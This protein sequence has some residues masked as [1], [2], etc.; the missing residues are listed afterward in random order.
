MVT[1]KKR[2]Y[3]LDILKFICSILI[4]V[5]HFQGKTHFVW[6]LDIRSGRT[7]SSGQLVKLFFMI[8]GF[9]AANSFKS[10]EDKSYK[11]FL[12]H[13]AKRIMPMTTIATFVCL[14]TYFIY[15]IIY[16][17]Y[18]YGVQLGIW[19][20]INSFTMTYS[21]GALLFEESVVNN[22]LW[23]ICVLF[24]C[25]TFLYFEMW[26]KKQLNI[27]KFTVLFVSF[28]IF[29]G[30]KEYGIN[31][32]FLNITTADGYICFLLGIFINTFYSF[33]LSDENKFR[34]LTIASILIILGTFLLGLL[35]YDIFF[36]NPD[37]I[38]TFIIFPCVM[39][40]FLYMDK[41]LNNSVCSILGGISFNNYI[42]HKSFISILLCL[43]KLTPSLFSQGYT[44][45]HEILLVLIVVLFST[46]SYLY[47]E[48][49]LEKFVNGKLNY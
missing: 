41:Y 49:P 9:F 4:I 20:I 8:S 46:F 6:F 23:Y 37:Y 2:I 27:N 44:Y 13:K 29:L 30:I 32:P 22:S 45:V 38:Y 25:Y 33:L 17:H 19:R 7:F 26:L 48:K 39:V 35:R 34:F 10:I 36:D 12:L 43:E 16:R 1:N 40:V 24:I 18:I 42:W 15:L 14:I 21:G 5:G 31:M 28:F 3:S 11:S 47:I